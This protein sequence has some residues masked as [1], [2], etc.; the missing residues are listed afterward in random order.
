MDF[1]MTTLEPEQKDILDK[2]NEIALEAN[3]GT[4]ER[5]DGA[6]KLVTVIQ[7]AMEEIKRLRESATEYE[8]LIRICNDRTWRKKFNEEVWEK[9]LGHKLS[10]PDFDFVY[11]LFFEQRD[12][13]KELE[14]STKDLR[15]YEMQMKNGEIDMAVGSE[16]CSAFIFS[17][18]Q[19]FR[20]NGGK[21]FFTTTVEV[22]NKQGEKYA[23]TI[24]KVDRETPAEQ[25]SRLRQETAK[26]ILQ[27][28]KDRSVWFIVGTAQF[29]Q[30]HFWEQFEE[31]CVACGVEIDKNV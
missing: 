19:I 28:L 26:N 23:L 12:K 9:E 2:L 18:I 14:N 21:N 8:D 1:N 6:P 20:Q 3:W 17:L 13:I 25:L 4:V 10:T 29:V 24:Q 27:D 7:E 30:D 5:A 31:M 11:K 22:D 16:Y 15:L